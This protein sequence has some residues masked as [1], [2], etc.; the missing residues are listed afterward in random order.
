MAQ[1]QY[2]G[3]R[4]MAYKHKYD[5]QGDAFEA[6]DNA[7][8]SFEIAMRKAQ[9]KCERSSQREEFQHIDF[10]IQGES[11]PRL[12]VDVKSRK[13]IKR[14]DSGFN[15]DLIWIEFSNV[16]GRRGWL[17]GASHLI[18][19]ERESEF[20]LVDR[21]LLA[22]LCEKLCDI[23]KLNVDVQMPL[24]TGYQRRGRKDILSLIKITDITNGIKHTVIK[25]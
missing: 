3:I 24:Y 2:Y 25:K 23:S 6:G 4:K 20:I 1:F 12:A 11:L 10:W 5:K 14:K 7:E 15:D 22:R 13:K 17:Y 18:A 9:L 16:Q 8:T 21:K 19:F